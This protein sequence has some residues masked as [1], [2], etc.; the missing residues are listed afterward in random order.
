M[1]ILCHVGMSLP[2]YGPFVEVKSYIAKVIPKAES[3]FLIFFL[4]SKSKCLVL[5]IN[6]NYYEANV[7]NLNSINY[8]YIYI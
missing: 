4:N 6:G 5:M 2:L 1:K 7:I 8:I 3:T